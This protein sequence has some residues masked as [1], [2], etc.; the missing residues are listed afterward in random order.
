MSKDDTIDR[1]IDC[2]ECG[3]EATRD[4]GI[5]QIPYCDGCPKENDEDE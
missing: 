2:F 4:V 1:S 3:K 5:Q